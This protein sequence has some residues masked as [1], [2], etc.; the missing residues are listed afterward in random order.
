MKNVWKS[1]LESVNFWVSSSLIGGRLL[2][3]LVVSCKLGLIAASSV[4]DRLGRGFEIAA[5]EQLD[6]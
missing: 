1:R 4:M 5:K 6:D 2:P 3:R